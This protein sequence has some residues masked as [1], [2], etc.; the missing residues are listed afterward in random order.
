MVTIYGIKRKPDRDRSVHTAQLRGTEKELAFNMAAHNVADLFA[1]LNLD[2]LEIEE[3]EPVTQETLVMRMGI[4]VG[5]PG[6]LHIMVVDR[7]RSH[8]L[9]RINPLS[10]VAGGGYVIAKLNG[11]LDDQVLIYP[12]I[13]FPRSYLRACHQNNPEGV[14]GAFTVQELADIAILR[15]AG[16]VTG[17]A[18]R[19]GISTPTSTPDGSVAEMR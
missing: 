14:F 17:L 4:P 8:N 6:A 1:D 5:E 18:A 16:G 2:A 9:E 3:P 11:P 10:S 7:G 19:L 15:D 13:Q 12:N